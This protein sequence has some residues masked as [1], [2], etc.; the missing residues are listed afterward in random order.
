[1]VLELYIRC[2][3]LLIG[4]LYLLSY[5]GHVPE[6]A[7]TKRILASKAHVLES[8]AVALLGSRD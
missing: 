3:F 6:V 4:S 1:M 8:L 5:F 2:F 7:Q